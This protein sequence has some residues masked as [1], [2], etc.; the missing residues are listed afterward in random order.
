[1]TKQKQRN[2]TKKQKCVSKEKQRESCFFS[3]EF[4]DSEKAFQIINT[5]NI[6]DLFDSLAD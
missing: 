4:E 6:K 3:Q 2:H 1:M 5:K